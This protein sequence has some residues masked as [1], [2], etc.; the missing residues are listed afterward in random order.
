MTL[1]LDFTELGMQMIFHHIVGNLCFIISVVG[2]FAIPMHTHIVMICEFSQIFL[3]TR[4]I[5]GRDAT[6]IFPLVNNVVFF[7]TYTLL[8]I[9]LFVNVISGHIYS[10]RY[11]DVFG[12]RGTGTNYTLT[13]KIC[14][15]AIASFFSLIILLNFFWYSIIVKG[16]CKL[17]CPGFH[18]KFWGKKKEAKVE[19][20]E[21]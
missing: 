5:I 6:G 15:V 20:K 7:I 3:N 12:W 10:E 14:F 16:I 9:Y 2:G 13:T 19:E 11:W 4:N 17:L 1:T 8:R 18:D 21:Q